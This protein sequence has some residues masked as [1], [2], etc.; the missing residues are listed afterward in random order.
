MTPE[1]RVALRKGGPYAPYLSNPF[2][3][4]VVDECLDEIERLQ[5]PL[6]EDLEKR[7]G[8]I[9]EFRKDFPTH[10]FAPDVIDRLTVTLRSMQAELSEVQDQ[11][12]LAKE[13]LSSPERWMK[14]CDEKILEW[15]ERLQ[16]ELQREQE[17]VLQLKAAIVAHSY[18]GKRGYTIATDYS[19]SSCGSLC[20]CARGL[21]SVREGK[22]DENCIRFKKALNAAVE[23]VEVP[24][25]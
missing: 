24:D 17:Q 16:A 9:E 19:T 8:T 7:L 6:P 15:N 10:S 12:R 11:L 1:R 25:G 20:W 2:V 22:H 23:A 13:T 3:R 14:W 21:A 18:Q 5:A 4:A